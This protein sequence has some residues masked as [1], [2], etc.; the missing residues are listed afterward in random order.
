ML[1]QACNPRTQGAEAGGLPQVPTVIWENPLDSLS[2][3]FLIYNENFS[4]LE[5]LKIN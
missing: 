4:R 3:G 5:P 1:V 2:Y